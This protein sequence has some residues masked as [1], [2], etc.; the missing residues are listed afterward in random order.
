MSTFLRTRLVV[1]AALATLLTS[2]CSIT[3]TAGSE[4]TSPAGPTGGDITL[5]EPALRMTLPDDWTEVPLDTVRAHMEELGASVPEEFRAPFR[6]R[7]TMID[8]G[9]TVAFASGPPVG[10]TGYAPTI[11]INLE[12]NPGSLRTAAQ[13]REAHI[14]DVWPF[15]VEFEPPANVVLPIGYAIEQQSRA[16]PDKSFGVPSL[17]VAYMFSVDGT[18]VTVSGTAPA[19]YVGFEDLMAAVAQSVQRP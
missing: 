14:Q 17:A 12:P 16:F 5:A 7:L 4:Q 15:P 3:F 10:D 8:S 18:I 6:D 2:A 1:I 19:Q 11:T 13:L 9:E